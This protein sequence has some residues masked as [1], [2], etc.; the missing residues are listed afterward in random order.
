MIFYDKFINLLTIL[1]VFDICFDY[2]ELIS[3]II[4]FKFPQN[5][6]PLASNNHNVRVKCQIN[7]AH[8]DSS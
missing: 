2:E 4:E 8:I 1:R 5:T 7:A 3:S 6:R